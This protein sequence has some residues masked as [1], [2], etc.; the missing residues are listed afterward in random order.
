MI[1]AERAQEHHTQM[2]SGRQVAFT[3][4]AHVKISNVQGAVLELT[5]SVI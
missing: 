2:L 1:E 3:I 5:D 4:L